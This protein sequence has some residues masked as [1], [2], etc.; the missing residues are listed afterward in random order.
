MHY[1]YSIVVHTSP[2]YITYLL[3][4]VYVAAGKFGEKVA[5]SGAEQLRDE[6]VHSV[7]G[8]RVRL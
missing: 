5:A 3:L 4:S 1:Y 2:K 6:G 7:Q 8:Q